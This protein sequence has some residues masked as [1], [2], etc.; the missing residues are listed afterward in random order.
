VDT[1]N[2]YLRKA[3]VAAHHD[4]VVARSAAD[5]PNLLTPPP[6]CCGRRS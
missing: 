6:S 1:L 2:S 5:V 3:I 4:P